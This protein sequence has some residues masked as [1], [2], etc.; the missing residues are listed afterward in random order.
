MEA[1]I[2]LLIMVILLIIEGITVGLTT[3]WFAA[4]A[5]VAMCA[6]LLG[7][8]LIW[9]ILIFFI[10]SILLL[11]FTR[12]FALKFLNP[13]KTRT[14]YED[15]VDRLVKI[16]ERVDNHNSTG[17]A[18]LNGQ[19]WT[20]RSLTDEQILEKDTMAKVVEVKGVKLILVPDENRKDS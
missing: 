7:L 11:A 6:N 9:Q 2:W 3:V 18:L 20:A 10:V 4:G 15:A 13:R 8:G 17:I 1:Y 19:E 16:T 14:N 5:L 12:P